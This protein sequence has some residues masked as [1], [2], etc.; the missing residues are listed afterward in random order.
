MKPWVLS[1]IVS[2]VVS[3]PLA[4]EA[5]THPFS[6]LTSHPATAIAQ[7]AHSVQSNPAD[8][9]WELIRAARRQAAKGQSAQAS[10]TLLQA[11]QTAALLSNSAS[12]DQLLAVIA[13]EQ[14]RQ[15]QYDR[16]IAI[17]TRMSYTTM[18]PQAC[19]VPVRTEA[20]IAIVQAY[21]QAGQ[22]QQ[23]QQ[24]A[25]GIQSASSR[26]QVLVP[27]VAHL[28]NQGEFTQA[29]ALSKRLSD[30]ADRAR[31][32][33]IK[34]YIQADRLPEAFA[35]MQTIPDKTERS[36]LLITLSQW[37]WRSGKNDLS[38]QI[39]NQIQEP[40][41]RTQA[42]IEVG[43]AYA[44]ADQQER[45][46]S[47]LSQA[48]QL[49]K[50]Q[51]DQQAFAQWAGYFARIGAFDR[52]LAVANSLTGY[53]RADAKVMIARA[54]AKA[55]QYAQAIEL[56]RQVR[57]GQLQPFGDMPDLKVEALYQI[58][59][60]AAQAG[61]FELAMLAVNSLSQAQDR[62]KAL[63]MIAQQSR[64]ADQP[65]KAVTVL[66]QAVATARSV[67]KMTVFYDRNTY[68]TVSNA[69]L[70]V[71]LAQ[72]YLA[73]N[74]PERVIAVLD[75][76]IGSARTLKEAHP[77]SVQEQVKYLA[78]I[79]KLYAQLGQ[80]DRALAAAESAFNLINQVPGSER[81]SFFPGWTVQPL[82]EVAQIFHIAGA[83]NQAIETLSGLRTV[84]STFSDK[85]QQLWAM[86]AIVKAY[87]AIGAE[88]QLQ[89]TVE[90]ALKL[91]AGLEPAQ[92]EWM[93]GRLA[94]AAASSDPA[95]AIQLAQRI[96]NRAGQI[97]TLAQMAVDYHATGQDPQAQ[98]VVIRLQQVAETIPDDGLR[99]QMLNDAI[100][101]YFVPQNVR[102]LSIGQLLQAG[103]ITADIQSPNLKAYN[104]FLIAQ[105][106]ALRGEASRAS[107]AL[108]FGLDTAKSIPD[109]VDRREL[110][111][112]VLE[113]A[114]RAEQ[115]S[116][117]AQIAAGF[118]EGPDRTVALQRLSWR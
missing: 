66:N 60:Q 65:Q 88:S 77:S 117:A 43:F 112:Q 9:T 59:R 54:Y 33:I 106:Y 4:A 27:M 104:W 53:E 81:S 24:F 56:A 79:A 47:I 107:Q 70:F 7:S 35:F 17:T 22:V 67:D 10:E 12:L 102:N 55:G 64:I 92:R 6:L 18:P 73:L 97:P 101:N 96:T 90:A 25:E 49:A 86:V 50:A 14:A 37:A 109:R 83:R 38:Y 16:A 103:Q 5:S 45:A 99:E 91:A 68:F 28:A 31:Y 78:A 85:Q 82:A 48:Y 32:A 113:E 58:V 72:D 89:E 63:R 21:L 98:A 80:R 95:Y 115:S 87:A 20:E 94:V 34:G 111:W 114:L 116:L 42:L 30:Q 46:L 69:G 13:A 29:I 41:G 36:A 39:A 76:A 100:R 110:L 51:P 52:A 84:S 118:E 57:D 40:G 8:Q 44:T 62:V 71:E 2:W 75:E 108:Q 93:T 19:C 23:A 105:A 11:E 3:V 1:V 74:Q 61:Q 15:G 26:N